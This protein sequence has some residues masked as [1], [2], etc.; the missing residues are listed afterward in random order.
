MAAAKVPFQRTH[1]GTFAGDQAQRQAQQVSQK[2]NGQALLG[3]RVIDAESGAPAGSGLSFTAGTARSIAHGLGRK[4]VGFF[5]VY[6]V[7][8]PSAASVRLYASAHPTGVSSATHVTV[9]PT[10]S[11]TCF[12]VVY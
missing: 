2:F 6:G 12:L 7:D 5:E 11:G 1:T 4:A 10:A 8:A 3:A 9:T